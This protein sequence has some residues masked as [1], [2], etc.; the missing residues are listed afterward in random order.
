[1][2]SRESASLLTLVKIVVEGQ[3]TNPY[4]VAKATGINLRSVQNL[5]AG[6]AHPTLR[7][8]EEIIAALGYEVRLHKRGDPIVKPGTGRGHGPMPGKRRGKG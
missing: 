8:L 4:Q 6:K 2:A 1:M 7:N 3:R 5:L